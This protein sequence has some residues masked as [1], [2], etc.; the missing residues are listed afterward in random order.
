MDDFGFTVI[1]CLLVNFHSNHMRPSHR[2]IASG[3]FI[4]P[5]PRLI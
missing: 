1:T 5:A 3:N 4:G 2:G